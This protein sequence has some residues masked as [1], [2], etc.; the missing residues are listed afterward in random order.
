[1]YIYIIYTH[2]LVNMYLMS[3]PVLWFLLLITFTYGSE[4]LALILFGR[5]AAP[6]FCFM[7]RLFCSCMVMEFRMP[8]FGVHGL[9]SGCFLLDLASPS[10]LATGMCHYDG[11]LRCICCQDI[12]G[13]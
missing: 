6:G 2:T 4:L 8:G 11:N 9:A 10:H 12:V 1:M 13:A 3:L 7:V 5:F